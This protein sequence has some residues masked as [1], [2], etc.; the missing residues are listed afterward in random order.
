MI[1]YAY[2][3]WCIAYQPHKRA[4]APLTSRLG[5][6]RPEWSYLLSAPPWRAN[7]IQGRFDVRQGKRD[8]CP[9]SYIILSPNRQ[10]RPLRLR[11]DEPRR[12]CRG[13]FRPQRSNVRCQVPRPDALTSASNSG[14][15]NPCFGYRHWTGQPVLGGAGTAFPPGGLISHAARSRTQRRWRPGFGLPPR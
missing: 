8:L 7:Q 10:C 3:L 1:K 6:M 15:G 4:T 9:I 5:T 14:S 2:L 11:R 12:Q 13:S